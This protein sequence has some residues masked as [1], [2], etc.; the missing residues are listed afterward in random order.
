MITNSREKDLQSKKEGNANEGKVSK[1][2]SSSRQWSAL[3][4]PRIVRVSRSFGGKD[5]HS[6]VC[7]IRG[8][9][10]RRVR[11]SVPTAIQLYDLQDRLGLNQPSKV[12]DWLLDAAKH[13]ID[14]LPPLQMPPNF[15]QYPHS[16]VVSQDVNTS[17]PSLASFV[18]ANVEYVKDDTP[19]SSLSK[20]EF[21]IGSSVEEEDQMVLSKSSSPYWNNSISIIPPNKEAK[22]KEVARET[23]TEKIN[24]MRKNDEQETTQEATEGDQCAQG[25]GHTSYPRANHASSLP[26]GLLNNSMPPYNSYYHWEPSAGLSL[27]HHTGSHGYSSQAEDPH[28]YNVISLSSSSL[29]LPTGSHQLLVYPS[30]TTPS[31]LP[32]FVT[33]SLECDPRQMNHFQML[34]S[35]SQNQPTNSLI[36][37][38]LYSINASTRPFQLS[39]NPKL[40]HSQNNNGNQPNKGGSGP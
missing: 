2:S 9:R 40:L 13:E 12:V 4:D 3:K 14:E 7:T 1:G 5:R 30:G 24:W 23:A 31:F 39:I 37:P 11:L 19:R 33:T 38:S 17:H 6:K 8:L 10:D 15:C 26:A 28:N 16:M 29:S 32:P 35:S 25:S 27:S 21:K 34:S 20:A 18:D 36:T 22:C